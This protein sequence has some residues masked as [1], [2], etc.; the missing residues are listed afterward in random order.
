MDVDPLEG[1]V[2]AARLPAGVEFTF[3][4]TSAPADVMIHVVI[5]KQ[6]EGVFLAAEREQFGGKVWPPFLRAPP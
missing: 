2:D 4:E 6:H 5:A 3:G 1:E